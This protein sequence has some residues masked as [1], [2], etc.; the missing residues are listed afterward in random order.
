MEKRRVFVDMDGV[1]ATFHPEKSIEEIAQP[2]YFR[3][4]EPVKDVV[5]AV[6]KLIKRDDI[7]VYILSSVLNN[8]AACEKREWLKEYL[9]GI[10]KEC[11]FFVPYGEDKSSF[12]RNLTGVVST[13]DL[14]IDDFTFNLKS[15]HGVGVKLLNKINNTNRSWDG[16]V[17]NGNANYDTIYTSV[18]GICMVA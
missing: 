6:N 1:L 14:L 9:P 3:S 2:G 13:D 16:F 4:L 12:V 11:I 8:T 15:W 18:V 5:D 7:A 17:V 10:A